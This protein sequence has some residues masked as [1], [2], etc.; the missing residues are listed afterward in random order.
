MSDNTSIPPKGWFQKG[1]RKAIALATGTVIVIGSAF[2][3]Q[4]FADSKTYA[5]M[6][7]YA[8]DIGGWQRD[9]WRGG[10]HGRFSE[11]SDAEIEARIERMVKHVAI[12]I[13]ATAEQQEK[14]TTL[15]TKVAKDMKPVHDQ[16]RAAGQEIHDLLLAASIDRVALEK[17]RAER[18][19]EAESISKSLVDAV[20]DVAE[21]L[22]AEQRNVLDE[23]IKQFRFMG[24]GRHR[25]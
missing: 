19:A 13:D 23:R 5:H 25:G 24:K 15:V 11:M 4:A 22:T 18:L 21:V 14:I 12:E 6:Q 7:L 17:V 8:G 3:V 2:G 1:N 9:G 16:M 10:H 20:A